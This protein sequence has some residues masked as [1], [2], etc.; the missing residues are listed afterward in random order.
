MVIYYS[1][2]IG[3]ERFIK[4]VFAYRRSFL[5]VRHFGFLYRHH[6]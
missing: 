5:G 2:I 6:G 4:G 1:H 3:G